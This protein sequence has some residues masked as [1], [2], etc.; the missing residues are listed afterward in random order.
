MDESAQFSIV[1]ELVGLS[2]AD[3]R[4]SDLYFLEGEAALAPLCTRERFHGRVHQRDL[5]EKLASGLRR[6]IRQGEW[7]EAE[8]GRSPGARRPQEA[9]PRQCATITGI[10][11]QESPAF[12]DRSASSSAESGT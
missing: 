9:G 6:A 7:S 5:V 12:R 1:A 4:Y 10:L 3:W 2:R 11:G 8:R